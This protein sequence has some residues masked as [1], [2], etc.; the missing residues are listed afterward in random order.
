MSIDLYVSPLSTRYASAEM[1]QIFSER[2]K[3]TTWRKLWI[4]LAEAERSL[5]L[6]ISQ[7]QI[8]A[9][10]AA[11]Q[12]INWDKV[13]EYERALNHDVVAHLKAFCDAAPL[14]API[15]HW[16]ATSTYLTDNTD[17]IQMHAALALLEK[18]LVVVL[19]LLE[20]KARTFAAITCLA[21]T[22]LQSAQP[23]TV[24][25]RLSLYLED[26]LIDLREITLRKEQL[27]FLGV[28]GATG[29]QASFL[30]L[31]HGDH[32]KLAQLEKL[33]AEKMG[34]QTLF[35]VT[36][37]TYPRKQDTLILNTLA[38][39]GASAH[40]FAT[41]LRLLSAFGEVE[42]PMTK[43]QVGSSA[44]PHKRNPVKA[45]RTCALARF[46]ISL[47]QNPL[48]TEA[49]QWLERS[50][51]D[52][53]NRRLT[54]AEGFLTADALCNLLI[55]LVSGMTIQTDVIAQRLQEELPFL[56]TENILMALV[57]RGKD[58]QV[59][60]ERIRMHV[61]EAKRDKNSLLKY[62]SKDEEIALSQEELTVFLKPDMGNAAR[63][64]EDF[65]DLEVA[66]VLQRYAHL[67]L[68]IPHVEV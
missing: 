44:M 52:S 23:T 51:D 54:L 50:L 47:A 25:K 55:H 11:E 57:H 21:Y 49:T 16:G 32:S 34:F 19:R 37:Q 42:E 56:A 63:Q 18:K 10:K 61:I 5:G 64:V 17:L 48:Y 67:E 29:T 62:L 6:P 36:G 58:R 1:S 68:A 22:H 14:A 40:K 24:G 12:S 35:T 31:F 4:A 46:L 15:L 13:K 8:D 3:Y 39:F 60:H 53:A 66:S 20:K 59:M 7:A 9:L 26:F 65:L 38:A 30:T 41:D 43:A 2:F 27:R 33:V 28:K 45:E